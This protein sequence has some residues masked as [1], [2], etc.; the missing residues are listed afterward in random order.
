MSNT[1]HRRGFVA[2][3]FGL[4]L[5][6]FPASHARANQPLFD[7]E[8]IVTVRIEAPFASLF[9]ELRDADEYVEATLTATVPG[10]ASE[11]YKIKIKPRGKTRRDKSVCRFPP[12]TVNFK[13]KS[14]EGTLFENQDKLKLVTHCQSKRSS[15][16]QYYLQE[17][18][19]YKTYNLV[20]D[21]SFRV[22]L[23]KFDY[24]DTEDKETV[25]EKF[26]FFIEDTDRL[27]E[28]LGRE[29]RKLNQVLRSEYEIEA[30][31]RFM[32]FQYFIGNL[33]WAILGG[34]EGDNCCHNS[35]PLFSANNKAVPIPYDFDY[36]GV[37]N[38][39]YA[40]PPESMRVRNVRTR[41][42]RGFCAHN[43]GLTV[44]ID[45]FRQTK[46]RSMTD[47]QRPHTSNRLHSNRRRNTMMPST[48]C[49]TI[50][51]R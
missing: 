26:G 37:I 14:V 11:S 21:E 16:E 51:K 10:R 29:R 40:V 24:I 13:K 45:D 15:Y 48:R 2:I 19:I 17:Y 32:L 36:A 22:R 23:A 1:F 8:D 47:L 35:K 28:R 42:Y 5:C 4:S 38:A 20:T 6:A 18:L 27:A 46:A 3:L 50:L 12:L 7:A 30:A 44:A 43:S 39:K 34:P 25:T 41:Y 9:R 31:A 49:L 33:D